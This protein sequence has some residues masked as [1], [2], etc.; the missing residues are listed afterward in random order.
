MNDVIDFLGRENAEAEMRKQW[1]CF[2]DYLLEHKDECMNVSKMLNAVFLK[3]Y[4]DMF[5]NNEKYMF[6]SLEDISNSCFYRASK[7]SDNEKDSLIQAE[8]MLP[9]KE[10]ISESNRFSPEGVE[11]LYLAMSKDEDHTIARNCCLYECKAEK[12]NIYAM[13]EFE[14]ADTI[15]DKLVVDLT[16]ANDLTYNDI[17]N[18]IKNIGNKIKAHYDNRKLKN[19][20][21][22]HIS[23]Q[24]LLLFAKMINEE[25]FKPVE[26]ADKKTKYLPFQCLAQYFQSLGYDGI[27]YK[28]TVYDMGKNIVLFDKQYAT[29]CLPVEKMKVEKDYI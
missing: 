22:K 9:N 6:V 26:K 3:Q 28:S 2:T 5:K 23:K 27:I 16:I 7:L 29:P 1:Q 4:D 21:K 10:Y 19:N 18:E 20:L 8:R 14:I 11:W 12:N 13:C 17:E 24:L 15:K 25:I